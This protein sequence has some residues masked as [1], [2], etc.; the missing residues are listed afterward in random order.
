MTLAVKGILLKGASFMRHLFILLVLTCSMFLYSHPVQAG[1]IEEIEA[2]VLK[3]DFVSAYKLT[4]P[5][6]EQGNAA[7][8]NTLCSMLS[9]GWGV[10][11]NQNEAVKW[12]RKAA[13]QGHILA[14]TNLG[15][16]CAH[17]QGVPQDFEEAAK[18]YRK[19]AD[20]GSLMAQTLLGSMYAEGQGVPKNISEA[21]KWWRKAAELGESAAQVHFHDEEQALLVA[22]EQGNPHAQSKLGLMYLKGQGTHKDFVKAMKWFR[23]AAD[24][25]I[26]DAQCNIGIIYLNGLGIERNYV[27]AIKWL[28][29]AAEQGHVLAQY[30]LA[31]QYFT[32]T[33][34]QANYVLT[35]KWSD[36]ACSLNGA[37][38][39]GLAW[40]RHS[41]IQK[42]TPEQLAQAKQM[43]QEWKPKAEQ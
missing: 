22:A 33:A 2:A 37:N 1:P 25:G 9:N 35:Y 8:Q 41:A 28:N 3:N 38:P 13:E 18:W 24:K 15:S 27:E 7:A 31:A 10:E 19:A 14:Q 4:K 17:G 12:C 36:I 11:K 16:M 6:A 21:T 30:L 34:G 5:L 39:R 40:L 23:P 20:Q 32:G 29:K 42:M 43:V 26:A